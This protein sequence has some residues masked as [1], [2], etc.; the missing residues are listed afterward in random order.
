M[1]TTRRE[2]IDGLSE[3]RIFKDYETAF[4]A[5]A[6]LPLSI[7]PVESWGLPHHEKPAENAFC[8][9][10]AKTSK[11]C[12]ACLEVQQKLSSNA[13]NGPVTVACFAGLCDTAVPLRLGDE[14]FGYLQTG[15]V[16]LGQ[17][18][19][20]SFSRMSRQL[21]DWGLKSDL[22]ELRE[23]FFHSRVMTEDQYKGFVRMVET[24]ANHLS[25]AANQ[26]LIHEENQEAPIVRRA[27][28]FIEDHY[29]ENLSLAKVAGM[30]NTSTFYFC[31][32]FKKATGLTFTEYLGRSRVEKA[33][34]LLANP[35]LRVSEIAFEVGF[36]SL[37]QF[38]RVFKEITGASPTKYRARVLSDIESGADD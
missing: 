26:L 35:T 32:L 9:T 31:K 5:A 17:P 1:K 29:S 34:G 22:T 2:F 8:Y 14:V 27:R 23:A 11:A 4:S 10:M 16:M 37:S 24:F 21:I 20:A 36:Q 33:K 7:T 25:I 19:E 13:N 38:N 12:A 30:V 15:Q 6:G 3:S 28:R 18:S